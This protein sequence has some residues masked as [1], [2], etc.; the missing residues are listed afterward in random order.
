MRR[1]RQAAGSAGQPYSHWPR[2]VGLE[3]RRPRGCDAS[4]GRSEARRHALED[5]LATA[6]SEKSRLQSRHS[7]C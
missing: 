3:I 4:A 7:S 1:A 5:R 2:A 6:R